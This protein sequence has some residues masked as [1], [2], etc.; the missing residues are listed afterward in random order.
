MAESVSNLIC[1]EQFP[2]PSPRLA[3]N[4]LPLP[5]TEC[6]TATVKSSLNLNWIT[7]HPSPNTLVL[8]SAKSDVLLWWGLFWAGVVRGTACAPFSLSYKPHFRCS[9]YVSLPVCY[10]YVQVGFCFVGESCKGLSGSHLLSC[11]LLT[12]CFKQCALHSLLIKS[13]WLR[14][15][16]RTAVAKVGLSVPLFCQDCQTSLQLQAAPVVWLFPVLNVFSKNNLWALAEEVTA[17]T[18]T[19]VTGWLKKLRLPQC[20]RLH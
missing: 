2:F 19:T 11:V 9:V 13:A 1:L 3:T 7:F 12:L 5:K 8:S 18:G 10:M 20:L 14:T 15:C 6:W 17:V 4:P 16:K